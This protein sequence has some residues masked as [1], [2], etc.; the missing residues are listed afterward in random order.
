MFDRSLDLF[1]AHWNGFLANSPTRFNTGK[2][3]FGRDTAL[4]CPHN[5]AAAAA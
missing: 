5:S 1:D 4:R 3:R 2:R